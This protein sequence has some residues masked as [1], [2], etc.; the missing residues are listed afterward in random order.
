MG[1]FFP[2][3]FF[4]LLNIW[5]FIHSV[6]FFGFLGQFHTYMTARLKKPSKLA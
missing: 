3:L 6:L 5:K 2:K 4:G 1:L